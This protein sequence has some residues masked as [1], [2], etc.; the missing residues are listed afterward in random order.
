VRK[1]DAPDY[2]EIIKEP[3]DFSVMRGKA[4]RKEYISTDG[5]LKDMMLLRKNAELYNGIPHEIAQIARDLEKIAVDM[6]ANAR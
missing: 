5:F 3:I 1:N 6:I 2:F 4:K